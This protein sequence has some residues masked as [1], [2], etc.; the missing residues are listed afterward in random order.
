MKKKPATSSKPV[1]QIDGATVSELNQTPII[2]AAFVILDALPFGQLLTMVS[3]ANR[4][5]RSSHHFANA[6][7]RTEWEGRRVQDTRRMLYGSKETI[8]AYK[9]ERGL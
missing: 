5:K 3:L 7:A 2:R 9:A 8:A 4:L 1:F 6:A